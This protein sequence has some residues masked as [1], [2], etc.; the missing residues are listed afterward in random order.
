MGRDTSSRPVK[1]LRSEFAPLL[2]ITSFVVII[3]LFNKWPLERA[4][5]TMIANINLTSF[6]P[7]L[8]IS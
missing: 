5:N 7:F 2:T 4:P 6:S 1:P 8:M 3:A